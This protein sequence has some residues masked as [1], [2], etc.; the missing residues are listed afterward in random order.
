MSHT[1]TPVILSGGSGT[2]LWPVSTPE[3]PKQFLPLTGPQSLFQQA[4]LRVNDASTFAP[5]LIVANLAHSDLIHV[6]MSEIG[7]KKYRIII[8]TSGRNTAP[9]IALAAF[10]IGGGDTQMLIMPSDHDIRDNQSFVFA[11]EGAAPKVHEQWLFTYG[12]VPTYAETGYGY[13]KMG[14]PLGENLHEVAQFIEKPPLALAQD[15]L[16]DGDYRWNA[17]I[18]QMRCDTYLQA[19]E[20]Y[21][22]DIF[23][24]C[25]SAI[26]QA[27]IEGDHIFPD[28]SCFEASPSDSI[29]YAIMEKADHVAMVSV[30]MGWSD[31]G[32]WNALYDITDKDG[33]ENAVSG[34]THLIDSKGCYIRSDGAKISVLG[35]QDIIVIS[36]GENI[37]ILPRSKAQDVKKMVADT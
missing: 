17:G 10:A 20:K 29:D 23:L 18:F 11:V 5:P 15:M 27:I 33:A 9:A 4:V 19:L 22:P 3:N 34:K 28:R 37:V 31:L 30:S 26:D 7:V 21:A 35:M 36:Q 32:N 13:L 2:R 6:Q 12:L 25:K 24:C 8:E 14:K 1:I 16:R